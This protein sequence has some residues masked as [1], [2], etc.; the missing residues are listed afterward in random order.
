MSCDMP[1][2]LN[3][4]TVCLSFARL[5]TTLSFI[6]RL[7]KETSSGRVTPSDQRPKLYIFSVS[8]SAFSVTWGRNPDADDHGGV[9]RAM[10]DPQV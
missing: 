3:L 4:S 9:V 10:V 7:L 5:A 2:P 1:V 8:S 6:S